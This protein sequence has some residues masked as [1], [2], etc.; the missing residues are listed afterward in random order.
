MRNT[1]FAALFAVTFFVVNSHSASAQSLAVLSVNN[2]PVTVS[3]PVILAQ[4][5]VT[6]KEAV[7][8]PPKQ[9]DPVIEKYTVVES[10]SLSRIAESR[11]T[12]WKRLFDKNESIVNPDLLV[13]G[14]E[15]VIPGPDEALTDRPVPEPVKPVLIAA[16]SAPIIQRQPAAPVAPPQPRGTSPGIS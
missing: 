15:L 6:Q 5:T 2:Q 1:A 11:S 4:L 3:E 13:I 9:A 14:S 10:D 8:L 16:A 12:T 7:S